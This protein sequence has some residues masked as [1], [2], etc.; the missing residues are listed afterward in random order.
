V[1]YAALPRFDFDEPPL[2]S[3]LPRVLPALAALLLLSLL[4]GA[5]SVR[6]LRR[7]PVV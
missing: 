4:L 3:T 7:F 1:A 6:R 2:V 5:V